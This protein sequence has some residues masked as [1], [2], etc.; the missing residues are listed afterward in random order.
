MWFMKAVTGDPYRHTGANLQKSVQGLNGISQLSS[1]GYNSRSSDEVKLVRENQKALTKARENKPGAHSSYSREAAAWEVDDLALGI[2]GEN[3]H[4][5]LDQSSLLCQ[6]S[7]LK[8]EL[9]LRQEELKDQI[10][11]NESI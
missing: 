10:S 7:F 4:Q 11:S 8:E 9:K 2:R 3:K 5:P 6:N 1:H